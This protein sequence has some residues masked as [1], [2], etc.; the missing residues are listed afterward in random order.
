VLTALFAGPVLGRS[1]IDS[2]IESRID[3]FL[4]STT[5]EEKIGQLNQ[6]S[7]PP[8]TSPPRLPLGGCRGG[9]LHP[10]NVETRRS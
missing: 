10:E 7:A 1:L 5:L 8:S 9:G 2:E 6:Y 3:S 4:E